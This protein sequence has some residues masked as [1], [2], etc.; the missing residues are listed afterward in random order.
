MNKTQQK[1]KWKYSV[2]YKQLDEEARAQLKE[3]PVGCFSELVPDDSTG[4]KLRWDR[5]IAALG[6]NFRHCADIY[7][8]IMQYEVLWYNEP[9]SPCGN[10]VV[11][12]PVI[13]SVADWVNLREVLTF[14]M[15]KYW[16]GV[17][18]DWGQRPAAVQ[19]RLDEAIARNT[20]N[21]K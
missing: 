18:K 21:R 19:K 13:L 9:W 20:E 6:G 4:T 15:T 1:A 3:M 2:L 11:P 17:P 7:D 5:S 8:A 14:M 10:N 16:I 12:T